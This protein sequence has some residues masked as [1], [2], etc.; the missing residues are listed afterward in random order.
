MIFRLVT[1]VFVFLSA[2]NNGGGQIRSETPEG[3]RDLLTKVDELYH[4][5]PVVDP[6]TE[7]PVHSLYE[8]WLGGFGSV[9]SSQMLRTQYHAVEKTVLNTLKW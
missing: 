7:A 3:S 9:K 1:F 6:Q 2:C 4:S 8:Q 5:F